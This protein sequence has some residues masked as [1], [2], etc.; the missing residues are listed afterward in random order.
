AEKKNVDDPKYCKFKKQLFYSSLSKIFTT[1]RPRMM[2]PEGICCGNMHYWCI[3]FRL[4]PYIADYEQQVV[5]ACIVKDWCGGLTYFICKCLAF[6][7]NLDGG[8]VSQSCKHT[9]ALVDS[10][11]FGVLWDKYSIIGELVV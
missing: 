3:I 2:T 7:S 4:G 9:D 10:V 11:D 1:L 8:G 6:P 5:L